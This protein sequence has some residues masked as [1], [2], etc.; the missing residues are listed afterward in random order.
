[1]CKGQPGAFYPDFVKS[2]MTD[3]A[4]LWVK[5]IE[6]SNASEDDHAHGNMGHMP[7][8]RRLFRQYTYDQTETKDVS[9][10]K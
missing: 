7:H 5:K 1:M 8:P 2:G 3:N 4:S 6:M 9:Q 10:E